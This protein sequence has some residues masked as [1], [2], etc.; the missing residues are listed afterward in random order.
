MREKVLLAIIVPGY[1]R[2]V[3]R[4]GRTGPHGIS[5]IDQKSLVCTGQQVHK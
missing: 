1:S 3:V 4:L 2:H 5:D